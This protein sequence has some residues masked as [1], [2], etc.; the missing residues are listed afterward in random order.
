MAEAD[1]A[2]FSADDVAEVNDGETGEAAADAAESYSEAQADAGREAT[3][4]NREAAG[5]Q[6]EILNEAQAKLI[7][8][9]APEGTD[10]TDVQES[11]NEVNKGLDGV[12]ELADAKSKGDAMEKSGE[13][14]PQKAKSNKALTD[15]QARL[16][17][18][19]K[20]GVD[21]TAEKTLSRQANT[22]WGELT[23]THEQA[24][25]ELGEALKGTDKEAIK[26]AQDKADKTA[27]A[28]D[29]FLNDDANKDFKTELDASEGSIE[30]AKWG[31][32]LG[33][34]GGLGGLFALCWKIAQEKTGCY[35]YIKGDKHKL[36]G[37][38]GG[39][40][41][42]GASDVQN[43]CACQPDSDSTSW[44]QICPSPSDPKIEKLPVCCGGN[45]PGQPPCN[46]TADIKTTVYYGY[47]EY[48]A[49]DVMAAPIAAIPKLLDGLEG[50]ITGLLK[51]IL[52]WVLIAIAICAGVGLI[53]FVGRM[54]FMHF[55]TSS[56]EPPP[57]QPVYQQPVRAPPPMGGAGA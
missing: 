30:W 8:E 1:A 37:F 11:A 57:E 15:M 10:S 26:K 44:A 3:E 27:D 55:I 40:S 31:K 7:G 12:T 18:F 36:D 49:L 17:K 9:L 22:K 38:G 14:D 54:V 42:C 34:I 52:K 6:R 28:M 39:G 41:G 24:L 35:I 5:K 47:N 16:A 45:N 4:A 25:T 19:M 46:T 21:K 33:V 29:D 2:D 53:W 20:D 56:V 43:D 23:E 51:T 32:M 48:N 13:S 50:G